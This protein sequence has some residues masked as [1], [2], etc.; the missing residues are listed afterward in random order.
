[1]LAQLRNRGSR[2]LARRRYAP[3]IEV[4]R[5][6][7][8]MRLGS[9]YGGWTFEASSDLQDSVIVSC[10]LGEDA[11]FDVEFASKYGA[12]VIIVDPTP[13]AIRHFEDI[14]RRLGQPARQCYVKGGKQA[15]TSYDLS[16]VDEGSLILE[17]S[18]LWVKNGEVKFFAPAN[19]DHVS[20]S[21][22]DSQ[23][24]YR[25][26]TDHIEVIGIT[27]STLFAKHKLKS[28]PLMKLDTEGAEI[29][30]IRQMLENSIYPRQLLVEFDEMNCPSNQTKKDVEDTDQALRQAGYVCRY[31]DG[32]ANFLYALR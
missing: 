7:D 30:V 14:Q 11:S 1:M 2:F 18:A 28:V 12:K 6:A 9:D 19:H 21:I 10:G 27:P 8:L 5:S 20:H 29:F 15:I 25:K 3:S 22:V 16:K 24:N 31:F 26:G 17:A 32:R 13:R 23:S 4:Q